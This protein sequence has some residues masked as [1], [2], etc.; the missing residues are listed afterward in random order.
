MHWRRRVVGFVVAIV[1]GLAA[2]YLGRLLPRVMPT[3][4]VDPQGYMGVSW[5]FYAE[6]AAVTGIGLFIACLPRRL[7][8]PHCPY[9]RYDLRGI[10]GEVLLCPECGQGLKGHEGLTPRLTRR[11]REVPTSRAAN[12]DPSERPSID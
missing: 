3:W 7:E 6:A 12:V 5:M 1:G 8:Y 2:F 11:G 4:L 10:E 9:C